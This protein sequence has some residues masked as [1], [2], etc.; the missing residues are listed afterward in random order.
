[1]THSVDRESILVVSTT[2]MTTC[3]L[4]KTSF[5]FKH[6]I[7]FSDPVALTKFQKIKELDSY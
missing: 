6:E 4:K 2:C 3:N 5:D 1:M 7:L